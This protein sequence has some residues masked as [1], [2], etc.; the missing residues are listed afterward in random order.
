MRAI[1]PPLTPQNT[2]MYQT[3]AYLP[4]TTPF[5]LSFSAAHPHGGPPSSPL[6]HAV[7]AC[8]V[9]LFFR[10]LRVAR[11]SNHVRR[12]FIQQLHANFQSTITR[13]LPAV[14]T[15]CLIEPQAHPARNASIGQLQPCRPT[16]R[17][18]PRL[19]PRPHIEWGKPARESAC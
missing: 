3:G 16:A 2:E 5:F 4:N 6:P 17:Q 18:A 9:P 1:T 8:R 7:L 12:P 10:P 14:L 15:L 11:Y 19:F 13:K